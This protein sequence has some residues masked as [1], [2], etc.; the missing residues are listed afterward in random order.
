[1]LPGYVVRSDVVWPAGLVQPPRPPAV[2]Y[3]D[4]NHYINLAKVSV[5]TAPDGYAE[6]LEAC[7]ATRA[8]RRAIFPLSSTHVVEISNIRSYRQRGDIVEVMEELSGFNYL[9]GRPQIM[10][11]EVESALDELTEAHPSGRQDIEL[12][13]LSALWS[14]GKRGG[15]LIEGEEGQE[16]EQRL[17]DRLGHQ[18]FGQMMAHFN[19]EAERALLTGPAEEDT[20]DLRTEGYAPER[21]YQLQEARATLERGQAAIL[22]QNPE[23]RR[24]GLRDLMSACEVFHELNAALSEVIGVRGITQDELLALLGNGEDKDKA[25][26]F[27]DGM[28]SS[29]VAISLKG[30]YHRN[31]QHNWTSNDLHDIDAVAL[32]LPYC[33]A[34]FAD[35]ATWNA[36][37]NSRELRVFN[38]ELP[39]RPQDLTQWLRDLPNDVSE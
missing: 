3:L 37:S 9:L 32:A 6:L 22:D 28:P 23:W 10:R 31:S 38:T 24:E 26:N 39:R 16:A 30:V 34:V 29:R 4:L 19:L 14:F 17:R 7:R 11:L 12:I 33:H 15:L 35:K 21:S 27:T 18:R 36:L 5:G 25:R 13:G 8:D 1:M 20:P 2:V